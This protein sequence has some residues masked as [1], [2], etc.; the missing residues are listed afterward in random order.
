MRASFHR[1]VDGAG[2]AGVD[3]F[4]GGCSLFPAAALLHVEC[5]VRASE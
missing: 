5:S 2:D 1:P 4:L 3:L